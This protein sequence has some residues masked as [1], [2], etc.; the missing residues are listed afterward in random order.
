MDLKEHIHH[1]TWILHMI[2]AATKYSAACI[3]SSKQQD[4]I[5]KTIF[6]VWF[7]YFGFPRKF[8]TDNGGEFN[9]ESFREMCEKFNIE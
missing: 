5:I 1:K 2:D 8:L 3:I 4:V 9:N 6:K 7:A